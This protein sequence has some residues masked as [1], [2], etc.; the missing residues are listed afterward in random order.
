MP[1]TLLVQ[2]RQTGG[3][4]SLDAWSG[5]I[6]ITFVAGACSAG[7]IARPL[8]PTIAVP[9]ALEI[10]VVVI[11]VIVVII[12]VVIIIVTNGGKFTATTFPIE[13]VAVDTSTPGKPVNHGAVEICIRITLELV[14]RTGGAGVNART[15]LQHII[16]VAY[17]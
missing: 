15:V 8:I 1:M 5:I 17:A 4:T 2:G 12:I 7:G 14:F 10:I 6:L 11:I 9:N 3:D 16:A 13:R